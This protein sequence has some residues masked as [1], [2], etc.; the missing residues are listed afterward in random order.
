M[1]NKF[2]LYSWPESK[3]KYL[4]R[5]LNLFDKN[6]VIKF[7]SEGDFLTNCRGAA[8]RTIFFFSLFTNI[9]SLIANNFA[10][11]QVPS[12]VVLS[13]FIYAMAWSVWNLDLFSHFRDFLLF[14]FE[15][16]VS[17]KKIYIN[18]FALT[19]YAVNSKFL[20]RYIAKK[21]KQNYT[22]TELLDPIKKELNL[23]G[24]MSKYPLSSYFY[25][26]KKDEFEQDHVM[27]YRRGIFKH[28]FLFYFLY[29]INIV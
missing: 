3:I 21:L 14:I 7:F 15:L 11:N 13:R 26:L 20:A 25:S 23:I 8:S 18:F 24:S 17:N 22:V 28:L 1:T 29:L 9:K 27:K 10:K 6:S 16:L 2:F 19:S 5:A 4:I 12:N